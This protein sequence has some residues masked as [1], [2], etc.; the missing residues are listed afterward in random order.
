MFNPIFFAV[1]FQ[2]VLTLFCD[3]MFYSIFI[4]S[5]IKHHYKYT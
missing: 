3:I 1:I 5:T 4:V 2:L